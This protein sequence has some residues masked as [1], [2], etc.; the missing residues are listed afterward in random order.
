LKS[1]L[2]IFLHILIS[3]L[4]KLISNNF[5]KESYSIKIFKTALHEIMFW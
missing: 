2:V 4:K 1:D 3:S 5:L